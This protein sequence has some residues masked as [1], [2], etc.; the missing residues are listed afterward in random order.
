MK[1]SFQHEIDEYN[2]EIHHLTIR[3][4]SLQFAMSVLIAEV[5]KLEEMQRIAARAGISA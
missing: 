4:E 5:R 3:A 1:M 2:R